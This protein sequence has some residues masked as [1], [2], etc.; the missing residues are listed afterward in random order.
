MLEQS[1]SDQTVI[2]KEHSDY[3]YPLRSIVCEFGITP[4]E[5]STLLLLGVLRSTLFIYQ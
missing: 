1:Y 5:W 3:W 4:V 2:S